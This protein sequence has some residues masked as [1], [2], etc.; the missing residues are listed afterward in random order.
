M[1]GDGGG[2]GAGA[3]G[4]AGQSCSW[5]SALEQIAL[6]CMEGKGAG[7][8]GEREGGRKS[9]GLPAVKVLAGQGRGGEGRGLSHSL[10]ELNIPP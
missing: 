6:G 1:G 8:E 3:F 2:T 7:M 10:S 4:R 5:V 9:V